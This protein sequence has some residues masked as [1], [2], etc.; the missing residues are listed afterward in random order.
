MIPNFAQLHK[1]TGEWFQTFYD[2]L[3]IN[4]FK[5]SGLFYTRE[6]YGTWDSLLHKSKGVD[7]YFI[8]SGKSPRHVAGGHAVV[9]YQ[10]KLFHDPHPSRLGLLEVE[11]IMM[12]ERV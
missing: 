3:D 4:G 2:F 11:D 9:Y 8:T 12:I 7:G 1:E 5:Y 10:G 6:A